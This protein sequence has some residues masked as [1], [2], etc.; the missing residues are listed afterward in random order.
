LLIGMNMTLISIRPIILFLIWITFFAPKWTSAVVELSKTPDGSIHFEAQDA[1]LEEIAKALNDNYAIEVKGLENRED[2]RITLSHR[3]D[4]PENLLK[5]ILR[6]IGIKNYAFE[7]ADATLKRL[8][9]V[10]A[11]ADDISSVSKFSKSL[12]QPKDLVNIAQIQSVIEASQAESAGL[13]EGDI[14]LEYDGVPISSAQ[15]LVSEVEKK[16]ASSQ[17]E[18]VIV[19]QKI[20]S[21]LILNGG[22]I[23][24]RIITKRI[25]RAEFDTYQKS[26]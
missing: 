17:I 16:S 22:F 26:D 21:R 13:Q 12:S 9:V 2:G 24:I 18:M 10:P 25:P 6:H 20:Q 15:Q 3:A 8:V 1:T 7:F 4:T 19:R 14:I 5:R 23:G 11:A